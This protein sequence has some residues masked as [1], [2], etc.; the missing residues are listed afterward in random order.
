[1]TGQTDAKLEQVCKIIEKHHSDGSKLI[2]ILQEIQEVYRYLPEE[3][4]D[5]TARKL[6]VPA[7][8]VYGVATF[9]SHFAL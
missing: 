4:I 5:F 6:K 3:V 7:A 2:P 8:Q 9:Y 1:M